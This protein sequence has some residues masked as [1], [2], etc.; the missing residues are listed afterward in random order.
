MSDEA[1][2]KRLAKLSARNK[3][4]RASER[5]M[6][7]A[8]SNVVSIGEASAKIV[9]RL[10]KERKFYGLGLADIIGVLQDDESLRKERE[11]K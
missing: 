3:R 10:R 8:N 2:I 9:D 6:T 5:R 11:S 4:S 7:E 1:R